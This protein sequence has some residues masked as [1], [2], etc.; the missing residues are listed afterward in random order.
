MRSESPSQWDRRRQ[1]FWRVHHAWSPSTIGLQQF[2]PRRGGIVRVELVERGAYLRY[3]TR[4][5]SSRRS[6]RGGQKS[7]MSSRLRKSYRRTKCAHRGGGGGK[8]PFKTGANEVAG[9]GGP[10]RGRSGA[11]GG[12]HG[13]RWGRERR[14]WRGGHGGVSVRGYSTH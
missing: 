1:K 10:R 9:G 13:V 11:R 6:L 3:G 4:P 12:D 8:G 14:H 2:Y 7:L 5:V